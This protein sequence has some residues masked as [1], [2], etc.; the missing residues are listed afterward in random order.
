MFLSRIINLLIFLTLFN[1]TALAHNLKT[2]GGVGATFHI[3][4]NHNPR[5]G[6]P[7]QAWF[8]LT[9]RG[10]E[11]IPLSEC[12]CKLTVY[13]KSEAILNPSLEAISAENFQNIPGAE[14]IFPETGIYQLEI[15]GMPK[16]D[17]NF[18]PFKLSYDVTV[19]PGKTP[20]SPK[21]S[22]TTTSSTTSSTTP[23][24]TIETTTEIV[25]LNEEQNIGNSNWLWKAVPI[26]IIL[27]IT[28][29][30]LMGSNNKSKG[31]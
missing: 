15:S 10:G 30:F 9:R 2:D 21:V 17:G 28:L 22:P 1:N 8:A 19:I 25:T 11:I 18:Q 13:L 27:A 14:I 4:P 29:A 5:A 23:S 26:V 7:A 20:P 12:D 24:T 6:E 31:D 16:T 3:E